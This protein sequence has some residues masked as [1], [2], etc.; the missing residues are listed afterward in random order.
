MSCIGA[1]PDPSAD[2]A[3]VTSTRPT[4]NTLPRGRS[5][6]RGSSPRGS[7][8]SRGNSPRGSSPMARFI[9][10]SSP[11]AVD[12]GLSLP[13]VQPSDAHA[14]AH[15]LRQAVVDV[16]VQLVCDLLQHV[17]VFVSNIGSIAPERQK[18]PQ[19]SADDWRISCSS[20]E[21]RGERGSRAMGGRGVPLRGSLPLPLLQHAA[22]PP[23][24]APLPPQKH[25]L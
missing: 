7:S 22:G 18:Q 17:S 13:S 6:P 11:R 3:T 15:A 20:S 10:G 16:A 4:A 21:S 8:P 2:E 12:T 1:V 25:A 9:R 24:P 19:Q 5:P 23:E 14:L